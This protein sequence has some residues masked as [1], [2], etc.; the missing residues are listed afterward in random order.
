MAKPVIDSTTSWIYAQRG[1]PIVYQ[2]AAA[3]TPTS[4]SCSTLPDGLTHTSGKVSGTCTTAGIYNVVIT[5]T[6]AD[7]TSDPLF[8]LIIIDTVAYIPGLF[9][10]LD[11]AVNTFRVS[12]AESDSSSTT[13]EQTTTATATTGSS[14]ATTTEKGLF[15][16]GKGDKVAFAVGFLKSGE[17]QI[18][19]VQTIKFGIVER[20]GGKTLT[21]SSGQFKVVSSDT[22]SR[23]VVI[24]ELTDSIYKKVLSAY[25]GNL[26][27]GNAD[28]FDAWAE[29]EVV[30]L[31]ETLDEEDEDTEV[32]TMRRTTIQF[33]ITI[34]RDIVKTV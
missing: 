33:P 6:N 17:A 27:D 19:P 20:M 12:L 18:I 30:W 16:L 10:E 5:A 8:I 24:V 29:I 2:A 9:I 31:L 7:G 4:W 13:T 26:Q 25:P 34:F 22:G 11:V 23:Y 28:G 3:N 32:E 14:E 21:V 15:S 1:S